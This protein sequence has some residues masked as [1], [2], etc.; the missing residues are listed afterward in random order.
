MIKLDLKSAGYIL[1]GIAG[2]TGLTLA[3]E[4]IVDSLSGYD[5]NGYD[6]DGYGRDGFNAAGFNR[7]G[8]DRQGRDVNGFDRDGFNS[9]GFDAD[10]YDRQGF[11]I[12]GFDRNGRDK[13][14]YDRDGFDIDGFDRFGRDAEGYRRNGFGLDGFNREGFDWQGYGRD[15]YNASG[16]N[17][18][19]HCRKYYSEHIGQLRE[20]LDEAYQQLQRGE[21]RYAVYDARVVMEDALRMI[22]QHAEGSNESDDRMLVNLKVCERKCL[23]DDNEFLDRLHDVRR[24]CNANGHE[25]D[26]EAGM[27]H[28]K[29]HFVVMQIRDLLDSA[30]Q[31]LVTV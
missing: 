15:R 24:I 28:N 16:L 22:V 11:D 18:A 3:V 17:R 7:Q 4:A 29:V 30:E 10:G 13:R 12:N 5:R 26:A 21:F 2:I 8:Y 20:R 27:S 25:L 23:L 1:G 14:G 9:R 19:G 31:T 6:A